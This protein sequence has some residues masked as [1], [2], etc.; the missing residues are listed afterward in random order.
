VLKIAVFAVI[1]YFGVFGVV[2]AEAAPVVDE[3]IVYVFG[4]ESCGLCRD[5]VRWLFNQGYEYKFLNITNDENAKHTYEAL[6]EKH[7]LAPIMPLSV[8]GPGIIV[9]YEK[10]QTT[11][12]RIKRAYFAAKKSDIKTPEDHLARAPKLEVDEALPCEGL[13]CDTT[14]MQVM[15]KIPYLGLVDLRDTSLIIVGL[16]LGSLT[17]TRLFNIG[18]LFVT[19]GAMMLAQRRLFAL[20]AG[21]LM[22]SVELVF[23]MY[24]FNEGYRDTVRFV[25]EGRY[26]T[27]LKELFGLLLREWHIA[28]YSVVAI[29]DNLLVVTLLGLL[30][31][32]LQKFDDTRPGSMSII[33]LTLLFTGGVCMTYYIMFP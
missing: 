33:G 25:I 32:Q 9:G 11:G 31:P 10:E 6:L 8:I 30:F 13:V 29:A 19:A 18:W 21:F 17:L 22:V 5:E 15:T 4:D 20:A 3:A 24:F 12:Q 7:E 23:Y 27:V 14:N 28:L 26:A 1:T 16:I 2:F